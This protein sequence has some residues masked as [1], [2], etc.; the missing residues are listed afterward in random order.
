MRVHTMFEAQE[1]MTY[2]DLLAAARRTESAGLD[3]LYRSDHYASVGGRETPGSTDAWA[4]LAGLAREVPRI[5]LGTLVSPV[6]FR[7]AGNLAKTVATV[8]GMAGTTPDGAPRIHLGFGTGWLEAEHRQH[9]FPFED[10]RTRFRRMEEHLE[11]V[12][13]LWDPDRDPF[14][15][16]GDFLTVSGA[17]FRPKPEPRPRIIVGGN[18]LRTTPRLAATY[19]DELNLV[20]QP[21]EGVAERRRALD[22]AC[23]AVGR[24]PGD[25]QLT[26]MTGCIVGR[27]KEEFTDRAHQLHGRTGADRPFDDWL[28]ELRGARVLGTLDEAAAHL[29][30]LRESGAEGVALQHQLFTDLEMI[31]LLG[32]LAPRL[33]G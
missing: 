7:R 23:D 25:V 21:P 31:D 5:T 18:G 10:I 17:R 1:G 22:D 24:D 19:A 26:V 15:F 12:R 4:T 13:G 11:V 30:A 16:S 9:G 29:A 3:G 6:T 33:Q 20:F 28:G 8:A 2:D 27:T 32:E 14:A